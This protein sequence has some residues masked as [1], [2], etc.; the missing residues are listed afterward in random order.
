ML[1]HQPRYMRVAN[2]L[3]GDI[4]VGTI[5]PGDLLPT[6]AQLVERF[7]VSRA[8]VREALKRLASLGLVVPQHGVG[9][10]VV[11]RDIRT[12]YIVSMRTPADVAQYGGIDTAFALAQRETVRATIGMRPQLSTIVGQKWERLT[13]LR[14]IADEND[15]VIAWSQIY[16]RHPYDE[17]IP[18]GGYFRTP[19]YT[20]IAEQ[21]G[22]PIIRIEQEIEA[23]SLTAAQA[24][25]FGCAEGSAGLV[26]VRRYY[27]R[28]NEP[29]EVTVS[30]YPAG[31]FTY[32]L[33]MQLERI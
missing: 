6:E 26:I 24:D 11:S 9:T 7:G 25:V 19:F 30:V 22:Q 17:L 12:H 14:V 23:A 10:R 27:T 8:T 32:R 29:I 2:A 18:P 21:S 20:L 15:S 16:L 31:R 5:Q 3:A 4:R 28:E 13:G 1:D 33:Q